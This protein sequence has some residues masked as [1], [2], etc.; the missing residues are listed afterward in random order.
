MK[1]YIKMG[2]EIPSYIGNEDFDFSFIED[3]N[4]SD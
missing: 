3:I 4:K 1:K 2:E